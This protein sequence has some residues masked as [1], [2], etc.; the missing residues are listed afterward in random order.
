M[1]RDD[2]PT[3]L[4][5]DETASLLR[6]TRTTIYAMAERAQLPGVTRIGRRCLMR[7]ADLLHWLDQKR[8]DREG[9]EVFS[10]STTDLGDVNMDARRRRAS[11]S[12]PQAT[13]P[14][15]VRDTHAA[16]DLD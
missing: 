4:T 5:V 7:S 16:I 11:A 14:F 10:A 6:T 1:N 12:A 13:D 2:L 9:W 15:S 8:M 3:C